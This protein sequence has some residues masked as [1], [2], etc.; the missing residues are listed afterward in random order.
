M[1]AL[2]CPTLP[3]APVQMGGGAHSVRKVSNGRM[4][5]RTVYTIVF[6]TLLT[7]AHVDSQCLLHYVLDMWYGT[8]QPSAG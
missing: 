6:L 5:V 2:A 7:S 4:Y 1:G 3:H 8:L